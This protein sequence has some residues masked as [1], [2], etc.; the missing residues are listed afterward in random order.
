MEAEQ[1]DQLLAVL[2]AL[3]H[4]NIM[5]DIPPE[6]ANRA[7]QIFVIRWYVR[8]ANY[9]M[10]GVAEQESYKRSWKELEHESQTSSERR[11]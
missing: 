6:H 1:E 2:N 10:D 3:W 8:T 4:G 9:I 7:G 11:E 5:A